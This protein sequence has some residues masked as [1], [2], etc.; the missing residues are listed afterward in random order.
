MEITFNSF[1]ETGPICFFFFWSVAT[2]SVCIPHQVLF[3]PRGSPFFFFH[4]APK[5]AGQADR[6]ASP[7]VSV[8]CALLLQKGQHY[9]LDIILSRCILQS[10]TSTKSK[11]ATAM[12]CSVHISRVSVIKIHFL[13]SPVQLPLWKAVD[14]SCPLQFRFIEFLNLSHIL[15]IRHFGRL[16]SNEVPKRKSHFRSSYPL[17]NIPPCHFQPLLI[18]HYPYLPCTLTIASCPSLTVP[19][20]KFQ[21]SLI[22]PWWASAAHCLPLSFHFCFFSSQLYS[23]SLSL[24]ARG[25]LYVEVQPLT[26]CIQYLIYHL[27]PKAATPFIFLLWLI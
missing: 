13:A 14:F 9:H 21:P 3:S 11:E 19:V 15:F 10:L 2:F 23:R 1:L 27:L 26:Q 24:V 12:D 16:G 7:S 8:R 17:S 5:A 4:Q 6:E 22:L 25:H 20:L 18:L